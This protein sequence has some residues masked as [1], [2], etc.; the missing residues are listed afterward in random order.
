MQGQAAVAMATPGLELPGGEKG[1]TGGLGI[2]EVR[3]AHDRCDREV[4]PGT[5]PQLPGAP[6]QVGGG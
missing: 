3:E 6:A 2:R 4:N 5:Q 1:C